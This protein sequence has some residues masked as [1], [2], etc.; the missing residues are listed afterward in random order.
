MVHQKRGLPE[1]THK[2]CS[3][4]CG[5]PARDH[6]DPFKIRRVLPSKLKKR[7]TKQHSLKFSPEKTLAFSLLQRNHKKQHCE[8]SLKESSKEELKESSKE[9]LKESSKRILTKN[10]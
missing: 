7:H 9:S 1:N 5:R 10:H 4:Q 3:G 6:T 8:E 2:A